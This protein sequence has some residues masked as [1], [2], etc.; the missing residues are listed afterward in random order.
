[1]HELKIMLVLQ[2]MHMEAT[3]MSL[4]A[5]IRVKPHKTRVFVQG[6]ARKTSKCITP[7]SRYWDLETIVN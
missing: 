4:P 6:E 7:S 3:K 2:E 5:N 1:M